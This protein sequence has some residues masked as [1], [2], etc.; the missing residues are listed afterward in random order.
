[1]N[2]IQRLL[3]LW[4][5]V[6]AVTASSMLVVQYWFKQSFTTQTAMIDSNIT[7]TSNSD[8]KIAEASNSNNKQVKVT[9]TPPIIQTKNPLL[10]NPTPPKKTS[11]ETVTAAPESASASNA[12]L[13]DFSLYVD[14]KEKKAAFFNF[15]APMVSKENEKIL[16]LRAKIANLRGIEELSPVEF[17]WLQSIASRYRVDLEE[18]DAYQVLMRRIN[19]IPPSLALA[20]SANESAW[21]TSRFALEGNN[22][23]GLWCFSENCGVVPEGR[24]EGETYE[25]RLFKT[26]QRSVEAYI[27]N[28]N[29]HYAYRDLR[30]TREAIIAAEHPI[31]GYELALGLENYS[32]RKHEYVAEIQ[33]MIK[34][35]DL[36]R[37]DLTEDEYQ[38]WQYPTE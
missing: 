10:T 24:P 22:L 29:R 15:L 11:T 23:F 19:I 20:Q 35:N 27:L 8:N 3:M 25:V 33:E 31:N 37:F 9:I 7:E 38:N 2:D 32:I 12:K 18:A 13:P 4:I 21:G 14:V 6:I 26:P 30:L 5:T 17:E 34:Y 28:L 16:E 36:I 1:M